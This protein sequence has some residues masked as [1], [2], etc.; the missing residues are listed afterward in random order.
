MGV[1]QQQVIKWQNFRLGSHGVSLV[2]MVDMQPTWL[3]GSGM[4]GASHSPIKVTT[5][6]I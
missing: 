3:I 6:S 2:D 5:D 1:Q 4:S